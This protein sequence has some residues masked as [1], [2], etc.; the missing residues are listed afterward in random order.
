MARRGRAV[1][2]RLRRARDGFIVVVAVTSLVSAIYCLV[3]RINYDVVVV[4]NV[5]VVFDFDLY[6]FICLLSPWPC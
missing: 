1:A 4:V 6:G 3:S 2:S 5:V